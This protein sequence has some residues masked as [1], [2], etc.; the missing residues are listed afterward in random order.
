M[1]APAPRTPPEP[2][3]LADIEFVRPSFGFRKL[4]SGETELPDPFPQRLRNTRIIREEIEV[5]FL[6]VDVVL[7][8]FLPF[9]VG[10]LGPSVAST[11]QIKGDGTGTVA[12]AFVEFEGAAGVDKVPPVG[13]RRGVDVALEQFVAFPPE[14]GR[15]WPGQWVLFRGVDPK[16]ERLVAFVGLAVFLHGVPTCVHTLNQAALRVARCLV[17]IHHPLEIVRRMAGT[18]LNS[19]QQFTVLRCRLAPSH[20]FAARTSHQIALVAAVDEDAAPGRVAIFKRDAGQAGTACFH[21]VQPV[22]KENR[23]IQIG[24]HGQKQ[25]LDLGRALGPVFPELQ[26]HLF[27]HPTDRIFFPEIDVAQTGGRH[28]SDMAAEHKYT[29][30][31]SHP[32]RLTGSRDRSRARTV[33]HNVER[34][35]FGGR[36]F[37]DGIVV[38]QAGIRSAG[39]GEFFGKT[40]RG[41]RK[42]G[43]Q[44][45]MFHSGE[46][47]RPVSGHSAEAGKALDGGFRQC[48]ARGRLPP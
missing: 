13:A 29:G 4:V 47:K 35:L 27:G 36:D 45:L 42:E 10:P 30:A 41:N 1:T 38:F 6:V 11:N 24:E 2:A 32:F 9:L 34:K 33:D 43:G 7:K 3:R 37:W 17:G 19:T 25:F 46:G 5:A 12:V 40:S 48:Q 31:F 14:I 39:L 15:H 22:L 26:E 16:T 8:D 23:D 20:V 21:P 18:N 28:P 44:D